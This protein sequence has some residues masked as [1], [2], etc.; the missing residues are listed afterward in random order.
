VNAVTPDP[1]VAAPWMPFWRYPNYS[2][3][4]ILWIT[5]RPGRPR[6]GLTTRL[7]PLTPLA[8]AAAWSRSSADSTVPLR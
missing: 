5:E 4:V 1:S 3:A 7:T 8:N 6:G 2:V